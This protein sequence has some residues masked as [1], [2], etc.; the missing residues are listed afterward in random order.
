MEADLHNLAPAVGELNGDRSNLAYGVIEGEHR[1]Y[2]DCDFEVDRGAMIVEPAHG[3]RGD[4]ARVWLYMSDTYGIE[5]SAQDRIM[6]N[7]WTKNDPPDEWEVKRNKR[8]REVQG[9]DNPFVAV[10][11]SR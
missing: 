4:V 11:G 7:D 3:I 8:I 2:G 5:L 10:T 6:F 1:V 9:N